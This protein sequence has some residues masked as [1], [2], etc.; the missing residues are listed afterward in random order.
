MKNGL[1]Q[2]ECAVSPAVGRTIWIRTI[3]QGAKGQGSSVPIDEDFTPSFFVALLADGSIC[4]IGESS[5]GNNHCA[6]KTFG[7]GTRKAGNS[8]SRKLKRGATDDTFFDCMA[9]DTLGH[10]IHNEFHVH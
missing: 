10:E 6:C 7:G 8:R 1:A 4:T 9:P 2:R 5:L 3:I